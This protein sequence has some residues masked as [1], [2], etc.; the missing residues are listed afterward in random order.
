[1]RDIPLLTTQNGVASLM[2]KKIPFTKEAYVHIRDSVACNELVKECID[3][4][5]MAGAEIIYAT[6][7][8]AL[9]DRTLFCSVLRYSVSGTH[10]P[11]TD[12]LALPVTPEQKEWWRQL[13]NQKMAPVPAA[14]PLTISETEE[15]IQKGRAFC[16][17]RD[18]SILGIGVAYDGQ[19]QA[20]ASVLPGGGREVV[21]ALAACLSEPE[22][23]LSVASTNEKAIKLYRSLGF[24]EVGLEGIWYK[25]Y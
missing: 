9:A 1:M 17:F 13:Y 10:L 5:R 24:D 4:C 21:L 14:A 18:C 25:I 7:H 8:D 19:L 16:V 6:G 23:S 20:I 22:I 3:I 12:A 2:F 11:K 15:L